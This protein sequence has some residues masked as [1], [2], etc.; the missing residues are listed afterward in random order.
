MEASL[1]SF[2]ISL[3]HYGILILTVITMIVQ[4]GIVSEASIAAG[5]AS[6]GVA[7]SLALKGGFQTSRAAF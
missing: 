4:L 7:I 2:V 5:I 1:N 6:A 3:L